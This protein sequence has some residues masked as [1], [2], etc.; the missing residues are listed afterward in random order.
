MI[1]LHQL[2]LL[3]SF[4]CFVFGSSL[5]QT[6]S[7]TQVL[8]DLQT[9][10][11]GIQTHNPGLSIYAPDFEEKAAQLM[12]RVSAESYSFLEHY[13]LLSELGALSK[14]GHFSLS[15]KE[16]L[17]KLRAQ[18]YAFLP[19]QLKVLGERIYVMRSY[20]NQQV[21]TG[22]EELLQI[23][24]RSAKEILDQI[25]KHLAADAD[26][27]TYKAHKTSISFSWFY[28]VYVEQAAT[29]QL[30]YLTTE[31]EEK[32]ITLKALNRAEQL[33][34]LKQYHSDLVAAAKNKREKS[35]D[36]FYTLDIKNQQA[37]L[38]LK[39]F[40][41]RLVNQ[42]KLKSKTFYKSIFT[43][44]KSQNVEDLIVD[45]RGNTG[46]R[47]EFAR[48]IVP[49]ILKSKSN[50]RYIRQGISK[51]GKKRRDKMPKS[52]ALAFKGKIYVLVDGLT[53]SAGGSLARYLKEYGEATVVGEEGG[54]RYEGFVAGSAE[55]VNLPHIG[56][57]AKVPRY[58]TQYPVSEQQ[59][60][61]NRGILPDISLQASIAN[62]L[63]KKDVLLEELTT[64]I[65]PKNK[66]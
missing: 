8:E 63:D 39:S 4:C 58:H 33:A 14:E 9:L 5:A 29:F 59:I 42:F 55:Y 10:A 25:Y 57:V 31:G 50:D 37:H 47:T 64:V 34:N 54:A 1:K 26:I 13:Q 20:S 44:I 41:F 38:T 15:K 21:L 48:D 56:I 36:D 60:T 52:S 7:K 12:A 30:T 43:E 27:L 45:L 65:I 53:F 3:C 6:F 46:G 35:L 66:K 51:S 61:K 32:M 2:V 16:V 49:F 11:T 23:N 17:Q 24:G 18:D 28:Y 22:G 19:L 62:L 40:D